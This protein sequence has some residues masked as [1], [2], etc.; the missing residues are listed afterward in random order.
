M[1]R[2]PQSSEGHGSLRDIQV[3]VNRFPDVFTNKIKE[4]IVTGQGDVVKLFKKLGKP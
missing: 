1:D 3:L 2:Y 4:K